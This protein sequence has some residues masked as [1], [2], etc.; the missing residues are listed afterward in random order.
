MKLLHLRT[1]GARL[2]VWEVDRTQYVGSWIVVVDRGVLLVLFDRLPQALPRRH[3]AGA[4]LAER[5]LGERLYLLRLTILLVVYMLLDGVVAL[6]ELDNEFPVLFAL[7]L[8]AVSLLFDLHDS[9][10]LGI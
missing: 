5:G 2:V 6:K 3:A 4:R 10:S 8:E 1:H 7:D 9:L